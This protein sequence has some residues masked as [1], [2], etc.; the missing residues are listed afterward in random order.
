M[1]V[2]NN[3]IPFGNSLGYHRLSFSFWIRVFPKSLRLYMSIRSIYPQQTL[4]NLLL[5]RLFI[6]EYSNYRWER[7]L[8][9]RPLNNDRRIC[10]VHIYFDWKENMNNSKISDHYK[11]LPSQISSMYIHLII[12]TKLPIRSYLYDINK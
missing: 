8:Y 6:H 9:S 1:N 2:L 4:R 11:Q 5:R 3:C 7:R 12:Y 10:S